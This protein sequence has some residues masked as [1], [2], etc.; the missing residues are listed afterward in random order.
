MLSVLTVT[1]LTQKFCSF[2]YAV[3][4]F[5]LIGDVTWEKLQ[6]RTT[7]KKHMGENKCAH[8]CSGYLNDTEIKRCMSVVLG[9]QES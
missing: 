9:L 2:F 3:F 1:R 8:A 5:V 4:W 7:A 6:E